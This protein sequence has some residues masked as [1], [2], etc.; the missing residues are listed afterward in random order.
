MHTNKN[1]TFI[2]HDFSKGSAIIVGG[3]HK[4]TKT[5]NINKKKFGEQNTN[6]NLILADHMIIADIKT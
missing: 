1:N 5:A 4:T 2:R 6:T 3:E